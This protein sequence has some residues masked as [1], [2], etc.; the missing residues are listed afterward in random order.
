M[1]TMEKVCK[2]YKVAKRNA[3]FREAC[4][5][6]FHREYEEIKALND[7]SF[8]IRD[9]EM[10]GYIGQKLHHQDSKRY[11]DPGQREGADRRPHPLG[12]GTGRQKALRQSG[13]VQPD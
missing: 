13:K 4:K 9:G 5:A 10:V 11:I 12:H 7:I 6:L 3:G 2:S 1:I 8:T